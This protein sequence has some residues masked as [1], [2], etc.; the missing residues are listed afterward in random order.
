MRKYPINLDFLNEWSCDMAYVLGFITADG[1]IYKEGTLAFCIDNNDIEILNFIKGK[2]SPN[3]KIVIRKNKFGKL[4]ALLRI[5]SIKLVDILAKYHIIPNKT[6]K[7]IL[8]KIPEEYKWDYLRGLFD[9]DGCISLKD[10]KYKCYKFY[11]C[12]SSKSFLQDINNNI[13]NNIASIRKYKNKKCYS[14]EIGKQQNLRIIKNK[15]FN[16]NFSLN[17][18]RIKF[19]EIKNG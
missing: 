15:L 2:M 10:K 8:P 19:E 11:L 7:E 13:L 12:S 4:E 6:G 9:G 17:R 16:G 18:K 1:C 3:S 14:L 5:H